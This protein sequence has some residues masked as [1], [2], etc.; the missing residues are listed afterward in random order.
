MVNFHG[1]TIPRGWEREF[2]NV[3]GMEAVLGAEQYK[4]RADFPESAAWHNTV[5]PFTRNVLGSMDYTPVTFTDMQ[6]KRLTSNA[7][8]LALSVVF[9]SAVQ[10]F[11][12]SIRSYQ[13]L[14]E[15]PKTFLKQ[16]PAA[17]DETRALEGEPGRAVVVARRDSAVWY[18]GG[19]AANDPHVS[20]VSLGFLG[21]GAWQ[22]TLIADGATD[23]EFA[24]RTTSVAATD[25]V[26]VPMR[27]RGGFV[28]RL[29]RR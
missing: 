12:D 10:H 20:R 16:V 8:E 23:R 26:E 2:P 14:P 21:A 7:H 17:W 19:I 25:V 13:A 22:M 9:Q 6:F 4:F 5:L 1:A 11:A 27:A 29:T 24:A 28:M 15:A 3:V 18:V